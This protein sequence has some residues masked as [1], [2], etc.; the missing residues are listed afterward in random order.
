MA[1]LSRFIVTRND[2]YVHDCKDG[3]VATNGGAP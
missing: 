3:A 1:A 2:R